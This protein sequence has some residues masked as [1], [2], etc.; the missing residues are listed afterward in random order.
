MFYNNAVSCLEAE[1]EQNTEDSRGYA[2]MAIE[3]T[4]QKLLE[5]LNNGQ[6]DKFKNKN[7]AN[8]NHKV[9][10]TSAKIAKIAL[11]IFV[12]IGISVKMTK[13]KLSKKSES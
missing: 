11:T 4:G 6:K 1:R 12:P 7:F 9:A 5:V 2:C 10:K 8:K 13:W 3:E